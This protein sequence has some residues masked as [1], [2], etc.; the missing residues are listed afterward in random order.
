MVH[1]DQLV[2]HLENHKSGICVTDATLTMKGRSLTHK[3][4]YQS[5][6]M[7]P[8]MTAKVYYGIYKQALALFLKKNPLYTNPTTMSGTQDRQ[9]RGHL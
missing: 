4:L 6:F 2:L 1:E 9:S 8:Y 3:K 7:H 5:I